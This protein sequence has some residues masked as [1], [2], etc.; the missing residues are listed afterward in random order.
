MSTGQL[1]AVCFVLMF[2]HFIHANIE[3]DAL[4]ALKASFDDPSGILQSWDSTLDSPCTFFHVTCNSNNKVTRVD[5]SNAGFSADSLPHELGNLAELQYL[6]LYDNHISGNMS[7]VPWLSLTNL[8]SLDLYSNNLSWVIPGT[9]GKLS[10]LKFI[11]LNNNNLE[12]P[13]SPEFS[14][15]QN[16]EQLD[17]SNNNLGCDL[18]NNPYLTGPCTDAPCRSN[19]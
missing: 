5:L 17:L 6:E 9:L 4:V 14:D 7:V 15:L 16:L 18:T 19:S 13:L 10:N 2:M 12:G 1:L 3:V 11:R 8:V